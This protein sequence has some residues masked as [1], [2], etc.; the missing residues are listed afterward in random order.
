MVGVVV[1]P[2]AIAA[3]QNNVVL[4]QPVANEIHILGAVVVVNHISARHIYLVRH[5]DRIVRVYHADFYTVLNAALYQGVSV[6]G[7]AFVLRIGNLTG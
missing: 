1:L 3:R 6:T 7:Q 5:P 2:F 4:Q